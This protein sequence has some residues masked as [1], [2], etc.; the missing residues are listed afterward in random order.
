M[1]D[2][3]EQVPGV[4]RQGPFTPWYY[5]L[6]A[7]IV[8]GTFIVYP[9]VSTFYL[10]LRNNTNTAWAS[11]NCTPGA[12]CWGIFENFRYAF[13][14][15]IMRQA[16][17]NNLIWIL[18]MVTWTVLLGLLIA[19]LAD[20]V[21]YESAAKAIIFLPM[22]ISFVG[23]GVI[24]RF[25]YN[26]DSG[27]SQ[28]GLLNAIIVGL[29]GQPVSWLTTPGIN[30]IAIIVVGVWIWTGFC[31]TILAAA[32]K[33]VPGEIQEAARVDG[34]NEWQVFRT[35]TIPWILPTITV[36]VTTM[37]INVLKI[38]D[39]VYVMTGGN[40]GTEVIANRMY[41]E[42]YQAQNTGRAAAIAVV[43]ILVI[44]PFM[45]INIRRIRAQEAA[46]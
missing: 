3:S 33:S 18:L 28:T 41:K 10:S 2:T 24:W 43:L 32:L 16:F 13:T 22:A 17:T 36:V 21:K 26:F 6:P 37:V 39:L 42:M 15:P 20:R 44:V 8:M 30:T 25:V 46:R 27:P 1:A 9:G 40:Y 5:L 4:L 34:A 7:L 14:S 31:M 45:I 12:P 19:T 29:G 35:V 38:F 23:A 11:A